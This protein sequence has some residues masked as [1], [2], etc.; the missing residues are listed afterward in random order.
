MRSYNEHFN[1]LR[2]RTRAAGEEQRR[3]KGEGRISSGNV[4][5]TGLN[6]TSWECWEC[7]QMWR[8][9]QDLLARKGKGRSEKQSCYGWGEVSS[10]GIQANKF[11]VILES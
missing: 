2:G 9:A 6:H 1:Q 7:S 10:E 3:G 11:I 4:L 8:A 5:D